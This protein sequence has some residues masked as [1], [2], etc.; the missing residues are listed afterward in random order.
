MLTYQQLLQSKLCSLHLMRSPGPMRGQRSDS[1]PAANRSLSGSLLLKKGNNIEPLGRPYPKPSISSTS[2]YSLFAPADVKDGSEW[3]TKPPLP[4]HPHLILFLCSHPPPHESP[5]PYWLLAFS[6]RLIHI[7]E[8]AAVAPRGYN[9]TLKPGRVSWKHKRRFI[10]SWKSSISAEFAPSFQGAGI[11][12]GE[13]LA[14]GAHFNQT[15]TFLSQWKVWLR[16]I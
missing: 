2:L 15:E 12:S 10:R 14:N 3:H 7:S 5:P 11:K 8:A 1:Y 13:F 4:H 6:C 9:P 16:M